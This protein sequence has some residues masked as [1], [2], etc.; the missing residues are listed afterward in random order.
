MHIVYVTIELE[1]KDTPSGGLASYT[2]NMARIF[3]DRG[4]TVSIIVVTTKET[5]Y[6]S[7][8]GCKVYNVYIPKEEWTNLDSLAHLLQET[9]LESADSLRR[10]LVNVRKSELVKEKIHQLDRKNKVDIVHYCNHDSLSLQHDMGIPYVIR[11]SGYLNIWQ[12]KANTINGSVRY[13]D[14]PPLLRDRIEALTLKKA[15]YVI[16]PSRL[17]ADIGEEEF[18]IK[19]SVIESPFVKKSLEWDYS[20][21]KA[22]NKK[23][24][25]YYGTM[26]FSKGIHVIAK[27]AEEFF[28]MYPD[29]NLVLAGNN[30]ELQIDE[31]EKILAS[32]YVRKYAGKYADR[33][34]YLGN[35]KREKLYPIIDKAELC[36]FPSRIENLSNA[37]IEA[38]GMG[39]IVIATRGASFEQLI[40]DEISGYLCERDNYKDFL[41]AIKKAL[42][43][44]LD[45]KKQM[46][47]NVRRRAETLNPEIAYH[48]FYGFY[49]K[50]IKEW[51]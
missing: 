17:L 12:G 44:S 45:E 13:Q 16:S 21:V 51:Q 31:N 20:E 25:L 37:C 35:L 50:I 10:V 27:M 40:D 28:N 5:Q 30:M 9:S 36:V 23:Y 18:G 46:E 8:K 39:K 41:S 47:L 3:S 42:T 49:E 24:I 7:L 38:M 2:A 6:D 14:N 15:R 1:T 43:M 26:R 22:L 33:V 34:I 29:M 4:N 11:I 19:C 32:E 48:N